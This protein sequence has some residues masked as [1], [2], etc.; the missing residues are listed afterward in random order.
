MASCEQIEFLGVFTG[1]KRGIGYEAGA[2]ASKLDGKARDRLMR[3]CLGKNRSA[4]DQRVRLRGD[5][6]R[7]SHQDTVNFAL[8]LIQQP[9]QLVVVLDGLHRFDKYGLA[10]RARAVNHTSNL[11]FEFGFH[12]NDEALAAHGNQRVLGAAILGQLRQGT[13]QTRLN[14][15]VLLLE[16]ATNATQL[17]RS[18]IA[19]AAIRLDLATQRPQQI[20]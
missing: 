19:Q 17:G 15:S 8:L 12:R 16:R 11:A 18:I 9:S 1:R 10:A 20:A 14:R 13:T 2:D 6:S 3:I 5:R 7:H 4:Q